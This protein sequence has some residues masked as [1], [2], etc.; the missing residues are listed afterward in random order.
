MPGRKYLLLFFII[1]NCVIYSQN[2]SGTVIDD[3]TKEPLF[4]ATVYIDGTTI[5]VI[6][7]LKG[8]FQLELKKTLNSPVVISHLGYK[9]K[10]VQS[11]KFTTPKNIYLV[12]KRTNLDEII[13]PPDG[14]SR[15]KKLRIFKSE[16]LGKSS[17]SKNCKIL[18]SKNITLIYNSNKNTLTAFSDNPIIITN[19]YLDYKISYNLVDFEVQFKNSTNGLKY[20]HSVYYAGTSFFSDLS[21]ETRKKRISKREKEYYGSLIHFMRCLSNKTL[22]ENNFEI[23]YN[24]SH[25]NPYQYFKISYEQE[26]TKVELTVDRITILF[27]NI[28]QSSMENMNNN[29]V[30]YID[31]NGNHSPPNSLLF[32]GNFGFKRISNMLPLDYSPLLN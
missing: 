21:S 5:G 14:W 7:D 10:I 30:F 29:D 31:K 2:I 8:D 27:N 22:V 12:Q 17:S 9:T 19:K 4:G 23:Y 1:I 28:D 6:T 32:R 13:L 18:N 11:E 20:S 15:E 3:R 25:A 24:G 26:L 16:F